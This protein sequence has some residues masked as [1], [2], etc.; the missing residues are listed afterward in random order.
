MATGMEDYA[1]KYGEHDIVRLGL[2]VEMPYLSWGKH[3]PIEKSKKDKIPPPIYGSYPKSKCGNQDGYF[4]EEFKR[5]FEGEKPIKKTDKKTKKDVRL[6]FL[7]TSPGK[8]H[9]TP[10]DYYRC[11][12]EEHLE[13]FSP[14]LIKLKREKDKKN[15][16]RKNPMTNPGKKGGPGY[17]DIC[18]APYPEHMKDP[19]APKPIK[20][21]ERKTKPNVPFY[22]N[23]APIFAFYENP[24]VEDKTP[25]KPVYYSREKKEPKNKIVKSPFLPSSPGKKMGN[26]HDGCFTP[27]PENKK[28]PYLSPWQI[29][30]F[31]KGKKKDDKTKKPTPFVPTFSQQKTLYDPSVLIS[32]NFRMNAENWTSY[33][34]AYVACL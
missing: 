10:D 4:E 9:S 8:K 24:Y 16:V 20:K 32:T 28:E 34:P 25:N 27:F 12:N 11:F 23:F 21:G 19:Y 26:N 29:T 5:L 13:S 6:P 1:V 33:K 30:N 18:L 15:V 7:P 17:V 2:F 22:S 3:K 14:A 31:V